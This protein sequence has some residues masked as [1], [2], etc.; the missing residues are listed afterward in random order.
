MSALEVPPNKLLQWTGLVFT[1]F[2][3]AKAAP[4][5]PATEPQRYAS[6]LVG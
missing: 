6:L 4:T 2:A 5:H 3:C 1:P